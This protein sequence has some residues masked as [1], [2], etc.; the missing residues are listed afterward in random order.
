MLNL[1]REATR[2]AEE[3]RTPLV[4]VV[5]SGS[6]PLVRN[7]VRAA[8][9]D[10]S[11]RVHFFVHLHGAIPAQFIDS[12]LF[13]LTPIETALVGGFSGCCLSCWVADA[14]YR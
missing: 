4:V 8:V 7:V 13:C 6:C 5:M 1:L 2:A 11:R 10:V 14:K 9:T 12:V 3:V